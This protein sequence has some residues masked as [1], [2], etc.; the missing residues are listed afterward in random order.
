MADEKRVGEVVESCAKDF[1]AQCYE[2]NQLPPLG[3]LVKTKE[4]DCE[5][6]GIIY[7]ARTTGIEPGRRPLARG[8][9]LENEDE[10]FSGSPQLLKL[11]K[12]EFSAL[13]VGHKSSGMVF[14]YLP[15]SPAC[16]HH[17]V[18]QCN[19]EEIRQFSRSFGFLNILLKSRVEIPVEELVGA[20]LR[21]L[22]RVYGLEKHAFLVSAGKE[23]ATLLSADYIQLKTILKGLKYDAAV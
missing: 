2:L 16:I 19:D 3:S 15:R 4:G 13:V 5:I 17:F 1:I 12:S 8:R 20:S 6:Y 9:D 23:L 7:D 11:F 21:Q 10:I 14:Q 22:S 18:F